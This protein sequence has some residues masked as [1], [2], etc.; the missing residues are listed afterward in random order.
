[1][2]GSVGGGRDREKGE[3]G[4]GGGGWGGIRRGVGVKVTGRGGERMG[5]IGWRG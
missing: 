2:N 3:G 4:G 1:V 5:G